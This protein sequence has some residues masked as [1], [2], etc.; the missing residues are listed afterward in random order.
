M[1][2]AEL[3][4]LRMQDINLSELVGAVLGKGNKYASISFSETARQH[5]VTYL[6]IRSKTFPKVDFD[7]VFTPYAKNADSLFTEQ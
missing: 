2:N 5:L 7:H 4:H 3:R 1:R 6:K